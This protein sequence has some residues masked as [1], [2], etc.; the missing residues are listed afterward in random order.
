MEA[1]QMLKL[2]LKKQHLNFMSSWMTAEKDMTNDH[3]DTDLL[4]ALKNAEGQE[5]I[6]NIQ[7][8]IIQY[9][10]EYEN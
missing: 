7:E 4:G 5:T 10:I 8:Q 6:N 2:H 3:P 9:I 1:L